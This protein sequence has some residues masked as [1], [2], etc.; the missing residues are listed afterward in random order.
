MLMASLLLIAAEAPSTPPPDAAAK[1]APTPEK[2][3]CR[4]ETEVGSRIP[5]RVCRTQAEWDE[6][7]KQTQEDLANSRND[8]TIAP[9]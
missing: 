8:R 7:Y 3:V 4:S 5:Q 9:N 6:I 1:K 2:V